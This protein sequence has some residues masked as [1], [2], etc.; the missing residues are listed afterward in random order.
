[1]G[2]PSS[3]AHAQ[4]NKGGDALR[5]TRDNFPRV[6]HFSRGN[7]VG[8]IAPHEN[9]KMAWNGLFKEAATTGKRELTVKRQ[10]YTEE[11]AV[12]IETWK[13]ET[14]F[15]VR[16]LNHLRLMGFSG[17][18]RLS[19]LISQLNSLL[20]LILTNNG[21]EELPEEIGSLSRLRLL[22]ASHNHL[23]LLPQSFYDLSSLQKLLLAHNE[24][25][26]DS[27]PP[28]ST[29]ASTSFPSL[30]YV[31]MSHN[32]MEE[33][34]DFLYQ[35]VGVLEVLSPHNKIR[36]LS[37]DVANLTNLKTLELTHNCIRGLPPELS[38]CTKLRV[39][40]FDDN[41]IEDRRLVKILDQFG[42]T[43]PKAV[44]DYLSS[45]KSSK[46]GKGGSKGGKKKKRGASPD[47]VPSVEIS[48]ARCII[49]ITRP[50]QHVTIKSMNAARQVRPYLVCAVVRDL[51]LDEDGALRAFITLQV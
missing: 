30:Q 20:E 12:T 37:G 41:E 33:L 34:P 21:L 46:S 42:A 36:C 16:G 6:R 32:V 7:H 39:I 17:M 28:Q 23:K 40:S 48:H 3:S 25:S 51:A 44:L 14:L 43:K 49:N 45:S 10:A 47:D 29:D 11:D 15:K 24:L 27:F 4:F 13:D 9:L 18:T 38:Q 8:E 31:D 19:P 50:G 1:M 5:A 26:D 35:S 22:D 2:L